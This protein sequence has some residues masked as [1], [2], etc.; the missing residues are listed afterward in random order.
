MADRPARTVTFLFTDIQGSTRMWEA[1]A[2]AMRAS[3]AVHDDLLRSVIE[4]HHGEAFKHTGDGVCAVF[5]S[6]TDAIDAAVAAQRSLELP[7]RMGVVSGDAQE[8]DGDYFGPTLN[9][10][11]RVMA[12]AHG[13]QILVSDVTAALVSG[14]DLI[15]LGEHRLRDLAASVRL[16]QVRADG[17]PTAF[18]A[19]RT[20]DATP[21]NLPVQLT[22]FVGRDLEV[23]E[24]GER[25]R[26]HRLVTLTGVGGVGKTRLAVQVAAELTGEFPDGVWVVELAHISDPAV[27]PDAV[28]TTLGI[29]PSPGLTIDRRASRRPCPGSGCCW[30]STTASTSSVVPP[31]SSTRS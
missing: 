8:R 21:G 12:A 1:D 15:D 11:A 28:A 10:A 25:V 13:G 5:D 19:L 7:V 31:I 3:L 9:R 20:L 18:P 24:L 22:S 2:D 23:K 29:T 26:A 27:V 4:A 6:A 16:F 14:V 17:L 30:C